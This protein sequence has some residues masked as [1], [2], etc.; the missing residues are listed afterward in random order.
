[1]QIYGSRQQCKTFH[2]KCARIES[3]ESIEQ[4][5]KDCKECDVHTEITYRFNDIF[6]NEHA[7]KTSLR[8]HKYYQ[9]ELK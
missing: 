8:W 5:L 9:E 3:E 6:E 7:S 4:I 1:M 2:E